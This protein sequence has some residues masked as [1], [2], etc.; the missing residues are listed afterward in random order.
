MLS[1]MQK[2]I[3]CAIAYDQHNDS[4]FFFLRGVEKRESNRQGKV[5]EQRRNGRGWVGTMEGH[6]LTALIMSAH[7]LKSQ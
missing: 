5:R 6:N 3:V 2:A 4:L 7:S 1:S